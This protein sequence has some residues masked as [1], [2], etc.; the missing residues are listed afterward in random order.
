[1]SPQE[2]TILVVDDSANSVASLEIALSSIPGVR[3]AIVCSAVDAIRSLSREGRM[4]SAIVTD[5]RMPG[6]DGFA[7]IRHVRSDLAH[8][9][10]P[11]VVVSA[12]TDPDTPERASQV[13]ANA[14]FAK[15]FSPIAV[16]QKLEQLLYGAK[17][18]K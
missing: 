15:P 16:R 1:M 7:L 4:I 14:F 10:I 8:C 9:S 13:G 3:V 17:D 6:M 5:I 18:Q 2:H 11:I 12:D